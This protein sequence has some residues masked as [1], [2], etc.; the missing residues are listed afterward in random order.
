MYDLG[1]IHVIFATSNTP[2]NTVMKM[3]LT[4]SNVTMF[5]DAL[6]VAIITT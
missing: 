3:Y 2:L 5:N 6:L 4:D 1:K